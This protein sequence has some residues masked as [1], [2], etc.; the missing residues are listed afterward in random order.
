MEKPTTPIKQ[1]RSI[2]E[3]LETEYN[4]HDNQII[5]NITNILEYIFKYMPCDRP[6]IDQLLNHKWFQGDFKKQYQ[7]LLEKI[8]NKK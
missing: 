2:K 7:D 3:I 8:N 5:D 1:N 4:F 6:S